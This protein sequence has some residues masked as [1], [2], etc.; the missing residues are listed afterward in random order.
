MSDEQDRT[1]AGPRFAPRH[2]SFEHGDPNQRLTGLVGRFLRPGLVAVVGLGC[3][4]LGLVRD[5]DTQLIR[6]AVVLLIVGTLWVVAEGFALGTL[7]LIAA[8]VLIL[9]VFLL[10]GIGGA[11]R[12]QNE[13]AEFEAM[14][15]ELEIDFNLLRG[16]RTTRAEVLER[17]LAAATTHIEGVRVAKVAALVDQDLTTWVTRSKD[18]PRL[19]VVENHLARI[20]MLAAGLTLH[21]K[22]TRDGVIGGWAS[23]E[24]AGPPPIAETEEGEIPTLEQGNDGPGTVAE[25]G[26]IDPRGAEPAQAATRDQ[27]DRA[28]RGAQALEVAVHALW[29]SFYQLG[30]TDASAA[31]LEDRPQWD[32]PEELDL[33]LV[34]TSALKDAAC[35]EVLDGPSDFAQ[36]VSVASA[37][38]TGCQ[39]D[40]DNDPCEPQRA[41]RILLVGFQE[42]LAAFTEGEDVGERQDQLLERLDDV[43][44]ELERVQGPVAVHQLAMVG[45]DEVLGDIVRGLV[46]DDERPARLGGWGWLML[47]I[48]AIVGYRML[49]MANG[50]RSPSPVSVVASDA[51]SET[52]DKSEAAAALVRAHLT[53]ANLREPS[54]LPGGEAVA[55]IATSTEA[56]RIE[57]QL[58]SYIVSLLQN[59][60]FPRRG[61]DLVVTAQ[62]DQA[63]L[64]PNRST[65]STNGDGTGT[66]NG[67]SHDPEPYR[68]MIRA[69]S[70]R[71]KG[72]VFS[73]LFEGQSLAEVTKAAAYFAAE[74]LLDAGWTTPSWLVWSS[75]DGTALR[76]YQEV[77]IEKSSPPQLIKP[78]NGTDD[79]R[80]PLDRLRDAVRSSPGTGAA[81]VALSHEELLDR[82]LPSALYHLLL[83]RVRHDRFLTV[84]Y[85]LGVTLSMVASQIVAHWRL[86]DDDWQTDPHIAG[87]LHELQDLMPGRW[88]QKPGFEDAETIKRLLLEQAVDELTFVERSVKL[89]HILV[90]ALRQSERQY[91]LGLLRST[92]RRRGL[93]A[94]A[95]AARALAKRR[96]LHVAG[97]ARPRRSV[98]APDL[99]SALAE[100]DDDLDR[101]LDLASDDWLVRYNAACYHAALGQERRALAAESRST[102]ETAA[103]DCSARADWLR[104]AAAWSFKLGCSVEELE[105]VA[106]AIRSL[107]E[108]A[109]SIHD[110]AVEAAEL[111]NAQAD[112]DFEVAFDHLRRSSYA[113]NGQ[114][115]SPNWADQDPDLRPL[116]QYCG[117]QR[118][119]RRRL[120]GVFQMDESTIDNLLD[121]PDGPTLDSSIDPIRF[122]EGFRECED[123][124][125]ASSNIRRRLSALG[126]FWKF[127]RAA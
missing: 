81:L 79:A 99:C 100:C 117:E 72:P 65:N 48:A 89:H 29:Q 123:R 105:K 51:N 86:E 23:L 33:P 67:E 40:A 84:R 60:A 49:E 82:R 73:H 119:W 57:N 95:I 7:R 98:A 96:L 39:T 25:V 94:A 75:H 54:P 30:F 76:G 115:L 44:W 14:R 5:D 11:T 109:M 35:G 70:S 4:T 92:R 18:H 20:Q 41:K 27:M 125:T 17:L 56:V 116:H 62:P 31:L 16:A 42:R 106:I 1:A 59:T 36:V 3:L 19:N 6:F 77:M 8:L 45:A 52:A 104:E 71:L 9:V 10:T 87:A 97:Q 34:S 80:S 38:V 22:P 2:R 28:E 127:Q 124:A 120:A 103:A 88:P 47:T 53:T 121:R 90:R 101:A 113:R 83:A 55:S 21:L 102:G 112:A 58:V 43:R 63:G 122:P 111:H 91:W 118:D 13:A 24:V 85:R 32:P 46:L 68:L 66:N 69:T 64:S 108:E 26:D 93:A 126:H 110:E 114:Q 15:H 78:A 37:C 74:R 107:D 12:R 50:R 61:I